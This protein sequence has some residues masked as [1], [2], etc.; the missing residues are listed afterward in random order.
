MHLNQEEFHRNRQKGEEAEEKNSIREMSRPESNT[1]LAY[2]LP[3]S[4]MGKDSYL[5][6]LLLL[7]L[8]ILSLQ[9][10]VQHVQQKKR[11]RRMTMR[12]KPHQ[13]TRTGSSKPRRRVG[14]KQVPAEVKAKRPPGH[15]PMEGALPQNLS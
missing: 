2:P 13:R 11:D 12:D 3:T 5:I 15:S 10:K 14:A 4:M 7:H 9:G 6:C 8:R 1:S